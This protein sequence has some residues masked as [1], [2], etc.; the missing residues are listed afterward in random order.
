MKNMKNVVEKDLVKIDGL[1]VDDWSLTLNSLKSEL[2]GN[3][4]QRKVYEAGIAQCEA[5]MRKFD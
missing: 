4:L 1:T 2:V 3:K 5:E